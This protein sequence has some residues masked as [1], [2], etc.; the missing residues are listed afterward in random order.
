MGATGQEQDT[1][2][3]WLVTGLLNP[4]ITAAYLADNAHNRANAT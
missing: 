2:G 3:C 1:T 4:F